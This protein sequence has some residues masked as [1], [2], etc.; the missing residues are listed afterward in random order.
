MAWEVEGGESRRMENRKGVVH[1]GFERAHH[2]YRGGERRGGR[3]EGGGGEKGGD[4]S[5]IRRRRG[6]EKWGIDG[7]RR[8]RK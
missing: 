5:L 2:F 8:G 1:R 7:M 6:N 3:G 4:A